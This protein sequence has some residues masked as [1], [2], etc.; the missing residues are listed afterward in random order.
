MRVLRAPWV[1]LL[2]GACAAFHEPGD[3]HGDTPAP[4]DGGALACA[5]PAAHPA[6]GVCVVSNALETRFVPG[7]G[8][9]V[10]EVALSGDVVEIGS[11]TVPE[12][13]F[14]Q[15][16]TSFGDA[17]S[18]AGTGLDLAVWLRIADDAGQHALVG[19]I[20]P[21]LQWPFQPGTPVRL[22]YSKGG[23]GF[24]PVSGEL[25]LQDDSGAL[26]VWLGVAGSLGNLQVPAELTLALGPAAC[27]NRSQ[28]IPRW[29]QRDLLVE[30][31]GDPRGRR[32]QLGY[33]EQAT[34]GDFTVT[35]H[36]IDI[37]VGGGGCPDAS[38]AWAA[39]SA[40]RTR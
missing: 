8:S 12:Q 4:L 3:E 35:H 10:L 21:G 27:R 1:L 39:L 20:A 24:G 36:G 40:W 38:V 18:G 30:V 15:F 29:E 7:G 37:Q 17:T 22:A 28:C 14:S 34:L 26:L 33:G 2:A 9:P 11:G 13:C 25:Q 23:G 6:L 5:S 16:V 19:V 32:E 31:R